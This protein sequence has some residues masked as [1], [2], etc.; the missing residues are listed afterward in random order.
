M[1]ANG[2]PLGAS[3]CVARPQEVKESQPRRLTGSV[4]QGPRVKCA[5]ALKTHTELSSC[6]GRSSDGLL[7]RTSRNLDGESP[8]R[9]GLC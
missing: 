9:W 2:A 5:K 8:G 6:L 4:S 1:E 3:Q 7:E